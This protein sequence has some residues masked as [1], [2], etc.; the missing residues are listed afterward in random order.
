MPFFGRTDGEGSHPKTLRPPYSCERVRSSVISASTLGPLAKRSRRRN[1]FIKTSHGAEFLP[2]AKFCILDGGF[3][4]PN[5]LVIDL[6]R[7]GV[8]MA[9]LPAMCEREPCRI[10]ETAWGAA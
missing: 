6:Q 5:G 3:E 2:L 4:R 8:G 7:H 1:S 9:V 10:G